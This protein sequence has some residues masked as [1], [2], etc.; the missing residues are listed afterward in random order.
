MTVAL[1]KPLTCSVLSLSNFS[2]VALKT[3]TMLVWLNTDH[4]PIQPQ[5]MKH[6]ALPFA[7]PLPFRQSKLLCSGLSM[8]RK[9]LK[10]PSSSALPSCRPAVTSAVLA[11]PCTHTCTPSDSSM[12][13]D[14]E[15]QWFLQSKT[16]RSWPPIPDSTFAAGSL[17]LREQ[18]HELFVCNFGMPT[19]VVFC[20]C[21]YLYRS[22]SV[23]GQTGGGD[24]RHHCLCVQSFCPA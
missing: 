11:G 18:W 1:R 2:K 15:P 24:C 8:F 16:V 14:I 22:P 13:R 21:N 17:N 10:P 19:T 4:P 20:L 9:C 12:V 23:H 6:C 7:T 5:R 3:V